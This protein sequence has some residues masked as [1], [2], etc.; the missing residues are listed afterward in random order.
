METVGDVRSH[1]AV[2]WI[3]DGDCH[4]SPWWTVGGLVLCF[5]GIPTGAKKQ[6]ASHKRVDR[7]K[8][9]KASGYII[10]ALMAGASRKGDGG[11]VVMMSAIIM[12]DD[13]R[14]LT[15]RSYDVQQNMTSLVMTYM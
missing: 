8:A 10:E 2:D 14:G 5:D 7:I 15:M 6:T 12:V 1:G 9:M 3:V 13:R 11:L 4:V